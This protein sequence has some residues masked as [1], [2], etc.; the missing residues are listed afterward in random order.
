MQH[1]AQKDA[2][3]QRI[4]KTG[5][6]NTQNLKALLASGRQ[7]SSSESNRLNHVERARVDSLG[8]VKQREVE[9]L[10]QHNE[11][12][13]FKQREMEKQ[14]REQAEKKRAD[15]EARLKREAAEKQQREAA[16]KKQ[17]KIGTNWTR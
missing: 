7:A 1:L 8:T 6:N 5:D 13:E 9:R 3:S 10:A 16:K 4:E 17:W 15:R 11:A 14:R 2:G 12:M